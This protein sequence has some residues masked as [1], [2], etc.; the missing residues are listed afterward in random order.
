VGI[1]DEHIEELIVGIKT[2]HANVLLQMGI[3]A[4]NLGHALVVD[5]GAV[6]VVDGSIAAA[7]QYSANLVYVY[8]RPGS[9][10]LT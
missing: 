1:G 7:S 8:R 6:G 9:E 4:L 2:H 10:M 3:F 5:C